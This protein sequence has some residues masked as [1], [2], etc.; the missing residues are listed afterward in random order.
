M[1][2]ENQLNA[3]LKK[4]STLRDEILVWTRSE[5]TIITALFSIASAL[6]GYATISGNYNI[7]LILPPVTFV[8]V[9]LWLS[10]HCMIRL[11]S[12][13]ISEEI[14]K[15]RLPEVIGKMN[16][17]SLWIEWDTFVQNLPKRLRD[18][19]ADRTTV[20]LVLLWINVIIPLLAK[21]NIGYMHSF[22]FLIIYVIIGGCFTTYLIYLSKK[23]YAAWIKE[24]RG[25]IQEERY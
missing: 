6:L 16:D 23:D 8:G 5:L 24:N 13:Y 18:R 11:L 14:E 2:N 1:K 4:Y 10:D 20:L 9:Y 22:T 25:L 19:G 3:V 15:R 7:L 17:N 21:P 12:A